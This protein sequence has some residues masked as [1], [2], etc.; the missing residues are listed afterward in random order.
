M[1][2]RVIDDGEVSGLFDIAN[3]TS[4]AVCLH[5]CCSVSYFPRCYLSLSRTVTLASQSSSEPTVVS[6]TLRYSGLAAVIDRTT[7]A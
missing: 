1:Q 3:G 6:V 7:H 2:G 5:H 4:R